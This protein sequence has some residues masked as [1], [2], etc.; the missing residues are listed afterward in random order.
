MH[1]TH[2]SLEVVLINRIGVCVIFLFFLNSA[3]QSQT[4]D[5][6]SNCTSAHQYIQSLQFTEAKKILVN[7]KAANPNNLIPYF[8]E[9][10][11]DFISIY[12][13][14]DKTTFDALSKNK[15]I[16]LNKIKAGDN[17]SPYYLYCQAEIQIQ[18]AFARL[19]FEEYVTAF[20]EVRKAFLMLEENDRKF[21]FFIANKKSL[22]MLHAIVGAIPDKYKWGVSILGMD[23]TID[24]GMFELESVINYSKT[25]TFLFTQ[26]AYLY[27]AFLSLYLQKDDTKA[28]NMVK[29]LDTKNNLLN[30]FCVAS[31]GM[32]TGKNNEA[33]TVLNNRP[34]GSNYFPF[35]FLDFLQGLA[36]LRKLDP[37]ASIYFNTFLSNFKGKNYI[38]EA[39]QKL[40]WNALLQ[41]DKIKYKEYMQLCIAKGDDIIDDDKQALL[42]AKSGYIPNIVLLR[43]RLL[44]DGGYYKEALKNLEGYSTDNFTEPREKAEF[45][46]RAGR[47][48]H[49]SGNPSQAKGF[50]FSTIKY[51]ENL[52]QYFAASAALKLGE[53]YEQEGDYTKAKQYFDKCIAMRNEEYKTG[54]DSQAKAGLNR[55]KSK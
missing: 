2:K 21:P 8:L 5:F 37:T 30:T 49:A 29:D 18:W 41:G 40:A 16:R 25:N 55:L 10:T 38:K 45:T 50:Y 31:I 20:N 11:I 13:S 3:I 32:R 19:K 48:Y 43:S 15:D 42:E 35:P 9:N 28:W 34:K 12:I 7:E 27:Y 23:G 26:E 39:Y 44:F 47:I 52:P 54:L 17:T 24:Q 4:F 51:G 36:H 46:Y 1:L 22:G 53:I 33:I 6:N 14:E